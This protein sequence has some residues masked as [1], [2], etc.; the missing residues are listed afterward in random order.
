MAQAA[1]GTQGV[2]CKLELILTSATLQLLGAGRPL[3]YD[4]MY[5]CSKCGLVVSMC[6]CVR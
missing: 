6:Y 1:P 2:L 4:Y 3:I 5:T